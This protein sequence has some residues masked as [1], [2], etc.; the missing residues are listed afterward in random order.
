MEEVLSSLLERDVPRLLVLNK[1]DLLADESELELRRRHPEGIIVSARRVEDRDRLL[2]RVAAELRG[3]RVPVRV[4]CP[5][6]RWPELLG[7]TARAERVSEEH[8][9]ERVQSEW[10]FD[11]RDLGKLRRAGFIVEVLDPF[12]GTEG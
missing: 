2:E 3:M 9:A 6:A 11:P 10:R 8:E 7:L 5:P 4:E 12:S 1:A